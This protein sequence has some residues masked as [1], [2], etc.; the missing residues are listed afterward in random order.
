LLNEKNLLY[1]KDQISNQTLIAVTKYVGDIEVEALLKNQIHHFGENR[2][3]VFLDK[4]SKYRDRGVV[5]HFIGHLQSKKVKKMI[6]KINYLHSLDR[7]SLVESIEKYREEPMDCFIEV[8]ISEEE[9][10]YGL[11]VEKVFDFYHKTK[12]YDKINVI[13]LMGMAKHTDDEFIIQQQFQKLVDLKNIFKDKY[14]LD[15]KLSMGMS[16]DYK[17]AIKMG[18]THLRIGSLLYEEEV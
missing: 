11:P 12:E 16:N 9:S 8:N 10:K 7:I 6:N 17:I 5:W 14:N 4:Y 15:M 2:V 18:S 13:G 3:E 1:I